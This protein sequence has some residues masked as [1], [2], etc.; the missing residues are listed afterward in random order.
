MMLFTVFSP[1]SGKF[2]QKVQ[3]IKVNQLLG[4][5]FSNA[6]SPTAPFYE[7]TTF[8]SEEK[9]ELIICTLSDSVQLGVP[10]CKEAG[11]G[12]LL[13]GSVLSGSRCRRPN[14]YGGFSSQKTIFPHG[15]PRPGEPEGQRE[16][17]QRASE[18]E[19]RTEQVEMGQ[20]ENRAEDTGLRFHSACPLRRL[21][22]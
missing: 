21:P 7:E 19:E 3:F 22:V 8:A 11:V 15:Y 17:S 9:N 10:W 4:L 13:P 1:V 12:G 20:W 16:W 18:D 14:P 6:D 5:R 2:T